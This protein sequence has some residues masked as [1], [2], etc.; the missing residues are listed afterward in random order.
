MRARARFLNLFSEVRA[1]R[2][3]QAKH[4]TAMQDLWKTNNDLVHKR[5]EDKDKL[6]V[7]TIEKDELTAALKIM[8][9][10]RLNADKTAEAMH[11]SMSLLKE[12]HAAEIANLK[13][14][15]DCF[16]LNACGRQV[17]GVAPVPP[18]APTVDSPLVH[19]SVQGRRLV[20]EITAQEL[21]KARLSREQFFAEAQQHI[22]NLRRGTPTEDAG[23]PEYSSTSRAV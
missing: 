1:L 8:T 19:R 9:E 7:L 11:G 13:S 14:V 2:L 17:F 12:T 23:A 6:S 10:A 18:P 4:E 15:I 3:A 16:S 5:A 20:Q 21:E 22:E